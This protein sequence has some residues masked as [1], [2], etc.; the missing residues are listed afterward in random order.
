MLLNLLSNAVKFNAP[1]G[2]VWL[3][4]ELT[5]VGQVNLLVRDDG[6]GIAPE[7]MHRLFSPFDRL[8]AERRGVD[9]P[10]IGLSVTQALATLMGGGVGAVSQL[11]TGSCF[12]VTL[13][14]GRE[15]AA[16]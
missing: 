15:G 13:P 1:D 5:G 2:H 14:V 6:P 7:L 8:G 3:T 10:G 11:G 16:N 4:A 12:T 9:G